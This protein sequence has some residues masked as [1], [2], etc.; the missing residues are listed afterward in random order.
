MSRLTT[1]RRSM[2][3]F[4]FRFLLEAGSLLIKVSY[5][6]PKVLLRD[7]KISPRSL[8]GITIQDDS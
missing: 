8:N 1:E 5:H 3:S 7:N 4:I 6:Y 2:S